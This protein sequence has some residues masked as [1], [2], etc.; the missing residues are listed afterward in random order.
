[1]TSNHMEGRMGATI[2]PAK[3]KRDEYKRTQRA[4]IHARW[5][6]RLSERM[7]EVLR[8]RTRPRDPYATPFVRECTED[9]WTGM[10]EWKYDGVVE[11]LARARESLNAIE[12]FVKEVSHGR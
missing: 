2:N 4:A 1:M 7:K 3:A 5:L 8:A 6:V 9:A 11:G 10:C 12:R